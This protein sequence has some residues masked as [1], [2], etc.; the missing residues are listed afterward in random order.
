M[1]AGN[2]L[3]GLIEK[4]EEPPFDERYVEVDFWHEGDD[5]FVRITDEGHGFDFEK[6]MVLDK[7]RMF[8]SHGKGILMANNLYFD[9]LSYA[10]PGNSVTIKIRMK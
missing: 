7:K 5:F 4:L 3:E 9:E 8:H 1:K 6:Y 10:E 2:Y